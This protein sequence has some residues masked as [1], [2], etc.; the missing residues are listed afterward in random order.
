VVVVVAGA[1]AVAPGGAPRPARAAP[2]VEVARSPAAAAKAVGDKCARGDCPPPMLERWRRDLAGEED[3]PAVEAARQLARAGGPGATEALVDA[4]ALGA[5]PARAA[6]E[7][8]ALAR[9]RD[10]R[11]LEV[12]TLYTTHRRPELRR[13]AVRAR[14]AIA[15]PRV[16]PALLDR[17]GDGAAEVRAAAAE[18]LAARKEPRALSRVRLLVALG[19]GGAAAPLGR[20]AQAATIAEIADL[21]GTVDDGILAVA[22]GEYIKRDDVADKLRLEAL[23]ALA[24]LRG[25]DATTALV[26][27]VASAP[28]RGERASHREARRLLEQRGSEP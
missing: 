18:T 21:H 15:D 16:V 12:A 19:D 11:A 7:L 24:P 26:E 4:L 25:A 3:A 5:T 28:A 23:A 17:L 10:A 14:G 22:L 9:L 1:T 2:R 27:Y 6:A 8:E 20:L 13:L